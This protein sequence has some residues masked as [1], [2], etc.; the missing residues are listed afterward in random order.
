MGGT[1]GRSNWRS[2]VKTKA[3]IKEVLLQSYAGFTAGGYAA[4]TVYVEVSGA[5]GVCLCFVL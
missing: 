4:L 5:R 3:V 2:W 1:E